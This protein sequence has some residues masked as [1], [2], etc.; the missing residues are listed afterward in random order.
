MCFFFLDV[1]FVKLITPILF[2]IQGSVFKHIYMYYVISLACIVYW[3]KA[4]RSTTSSASKARVKREFR[5][6]TQWCYETFWRQKIESKFHVN[7]IWL[8]ITRFR[9]NQLECFQEH[10][11]F[12]GLTKT[13][14]RKRLNQYFFETKIYHINMN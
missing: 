11:A 3:C 8:P 7:C 10:Y 13:N 6:R 2:Q 14:W 9:E 5:L 4:S 1:L 12:K